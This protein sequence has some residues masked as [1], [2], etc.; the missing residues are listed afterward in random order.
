MCCV[1]PL[2]PHA[3]YRSAEI[4]VPVCPTWSVCGR[5]PALVTTRE[6]PTAPPSSPASSSMIANP[7]AEPTPRPPPTTTFASRSETP[8]L[9]S[10]RRSSTLGE[11]SSSAISVST[12]PISAA[13][14]VCGATVRSS[15]E[16]CSRASPRRLPPQRWRVTTSPSIAVAFAANGWSSIAPTC[17]SSSFPR[18]EPAATIASAGSAASALVQDSDDARRCVRAF[19]Q[20]LRLLALSFRD[21]QPQL[22]ELR[23][24]RRDGCARERLLLRAQAA[25]NGRV[26][27]Q[28]QALQH[29]QHGRERRLVHV[30]R[31]ADVALAADRAVAQ[32]DLLQ[33]GDDR[34]AERMPDADPDLVAGGIGRL[35][36]EEEEVERLRL[37]ADGLDDRTR[38]RLRVPVLA[39]RLQQD[40]AIGPD[41][42]AVAEL[43]LRLGRAERQRYDLA[44]LCLGDPHSL[45]DRALLVR[46]DREAEV[47]RLDRLLIDGEHHLPAGDRDALHTAKDP[48]ERI[49]SLSG[50]NGGREPTTSTE[51]GRSCSM[52]WT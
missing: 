46:R 17:A 13:G 52:Y 49:L 18:S 14:C 36:A 30:A 50:S 20:D 3:T 43:F 37:C 10:S 45:L 35:V 11:P 4:F 39:L 5:Q 25:R 12:S 47:L 1:A 7:S 21:D 42:H 28:V 9:A 22:L 41:R 23:R 51:T 40:P 29:R 31:A 34:Q 27:R 16:P 15:G 2:I 32:L 19:A 48:H 8:V 6:H 44:A 26:A 33:A 38:R 24:R